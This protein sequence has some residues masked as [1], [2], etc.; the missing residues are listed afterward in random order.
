[1][2][3][4]QLKS[5]VIFSSSLARTQDF[6]TDILGLK[7]LHSSDHFSELSDGQHRLMLRTAPTLAH[8][9][10]GFSPMLLFQVED[11][12]Q[13]CER[14]KEEYKCEMDG[15]IVEDEYLKIAC[16]KTECGLSIS[17]QQVLQANPDEV[18]YEKFT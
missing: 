17:V 6:M 3:R 14:A 1:M 9:A 2:S 18:E 5:I 13:L 8:A 4:A 15:D 11:L 12:Q 7:L 10:R 16:L